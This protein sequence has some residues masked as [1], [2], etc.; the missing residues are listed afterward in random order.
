MMKLFIALLLVSY[1]Y[2]LTFTA[3]SDSIANAG[4]FKYRKIDK[5]FSGLIG[6]YSSVA[7]DGSGNNVSGS[8]TANVLLMGVHVTPYVHAPFNWVASIKGTATYSISSLD[9]SLTANV[10]ASLII[11]AFS[12]IDERKPDGTLVRRR[13]LK[14]MLFTASAGADGKLSYASYKSTGFFPTEKVEIHYFVAEELGEVTFEGV[15]TVASPKTLESFIIISEWQY[16]KPENYLVLVSGVATGSLTGTATLSARST[17]SS[18][19][20]E[21]K[22][23]AYFSDEAQMDGKNKKVVIRQTTVDVTVAV[24]NTAIQAKLSAVYNGVYTAQVVES[25]FQNQPG[26]NKIVYDPTAGAGA[27]MQNGVSKV[28]FFAVAY[29]LALLI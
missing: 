22:V 14:D 24:N 4:D 12:H 26:A 20:G 5:Y 23:Y 15:T 28:V 10:G 16:A 9:S 8:A 29:I 18:G 19:E 17:L 11:T 27:V 6:F 13:L 2:S 1:V 25:S 21:N 3:G 7:V